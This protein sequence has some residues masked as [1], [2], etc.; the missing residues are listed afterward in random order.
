M[1]VTTYYEICLATG[2]V[3]LL[4]RLG[5]SLFR[6]LRKNASYH[7]RSWTSPLLPTWMCGQA[8]ISRFEAILLGCFLL[9][10][11][12]CLG[13]GVDSGQGPTK[14]TR[15]L[16]EIA[17]INLMPLFCGAHM[18]SIATICGISYERY[19]IAHIWIG[20]VVILE[21]AL[22][23]LLAVLQGGN[24]IHNMAGLVVRRSLI[25]GILI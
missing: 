13:I 9:V 8:I 22:H 21:I 14:L 15:R 3:I 1:E 10:N 6:V 5:L 19:S 12:L 20:V 4:L 25:V 23:T 11:G 7:L 24:P 16:G 17:L 2:F 18:N